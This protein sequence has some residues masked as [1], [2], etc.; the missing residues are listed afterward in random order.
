MEQYIFFQNPFMN[1]ASGNFFLA[2]KISTF[3]N[4]ALF[5]YAADPVKGPLYS[6]YHTL[7]Q[8]LETQY[9][10][11][12]TAGGN[13]KGQTLNL[14]TLMKQSTAKLNSWEGP[15]QTVFAKGTT[16]YESLFPLGRRPFNTG[17]I[18]TRI[19]AFSE[20]E[21]AI[22]SNASLATV[23]TSVHNFWQ[24]L[25]DARAAQQ[26]LKTGTSTASSALD[27]AVNNA[28]VQMW[29]N[30]CKL[31]AAT[32]TQMDLVAPFFDIDT[33]RENL[34]TVY[35]HGILGFK[36]EHVFH[37]KMD[38]VHDL[39]RLKNKGDD[40]LGFYFTNDLN[41]LPQAGWNMVIVPPHSEVVVNPTELGYA[42]DKRQLN[43]HND[44]PTPGTF[45]V[46]WE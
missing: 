40:R 16:G 25:H 42:D 30:M 24:Q 9:A 3:H 41:D 11:W 13:K 36:V 43:C 35:T 2:L 19:S 39:L 21:G 23:K 20:L 34:Q 12:K 29:V 8:Q 5:P 7:H 10:A 14:R 46:D 31:I 6:T 44:T 17:A 15:I 32:P 1:A 33:I 22:G 4:N 28:M 27:T 38:V 26:G 45:E 37:H 18:E